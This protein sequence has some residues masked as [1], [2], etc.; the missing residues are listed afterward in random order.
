MNDDSTKFI[1]IVHSQRHI[2]Q[3]TRKKEVAYKIWGW[4]RR[5]CS[6]EHNRLNQVSFWGWYFHNLFGERYKDPGSEF[7]LIPDLHISPTRRW[8]KIR[9]IWRW[10]E[11]GWGIRSSGFL[12]RTWRG[13]ADV[14][15]WLL[16]LGHV[17]SPQS[18]AVQVFLWGQRQQ[19]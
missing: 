2:L 13:S 12:V 4:L 6:W 3:V 9:I 11:W 16:H 7:R 8:Q 15:V 17:N 1:K 14:N 5:K 18:M 19:G 10:G